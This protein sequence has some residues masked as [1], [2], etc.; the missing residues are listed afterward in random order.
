M[1]FNVALSGIRAA[2]M[3]LEVTGNNISNASTIGFKES[4]TEFGDVYANSLFGSG[5]FQVGSGVRVT[6]VA[7]QFDQGNLAYT[8]NE[9]DLAISGEGFFIQEIGGERSYTRDG[10]FSLD[11]NGFVLSN[12]G[13]VIQ[14][15]GA[16]E[17]GNIVGVLT[18]LQISTENIEPMQSDTVDWRLNF[19]AEQEPP[20]TTVFDP[21]DATSYNS[22]TSVTIYDSLGV[23]HTLTQYFVQAGSTADRTDWQAYSYIDGEAAVVDAA[24]DPQSSLITFDSTGQLVAVDG[25]DGNTEI[26]IPDWAPIEATDPERTTLTVDYMGS[27]QYASDF[28]V[29]DV[30]QDGY[31]TGRMSGLEIN[32]SGIIFARFTNGQ[33]RVIGQIALAEFTNNNGLEPTGTNSWSETYSSGEPNIG[34]PGSAVLGYINSGALEESNTDLTEQLVQLIIAQRNYQANSKTIETADQITQTIINI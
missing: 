8:E 7:Q 9:L 4:R 3:D 19:D 1:P 26:I 30:T 34:S 31:T 17:D 2:A 24:G 23:S 21:A 16:D 28:G 15:F 13:G 33:A 11:E 25:V 5:A 22:A 20:V 6:D 12:S 14:G 32:D 29:T 10:T 18:D 27:S